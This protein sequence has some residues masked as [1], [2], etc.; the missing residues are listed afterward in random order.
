[1]EA[2][3]GISNVAELLARI[4]QGMAP[5]ALRLFAAQGLLPVSREELIRV[6]LILAA[7]LFLPK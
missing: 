6:V 2:S 5:R 4:R 1:M 3:G 7:V